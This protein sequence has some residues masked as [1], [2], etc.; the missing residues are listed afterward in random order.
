MRVKVCGVTSVADARMCVEAGVDAI[1]LSLVPGSPRRV[2]WD[3]AQEIADACRSELLV[4][5]V[6]AD[7]PKEEVDRALH[8]LK[9]GCLQF[10]GI[11]APE[12]VAA[13]LPHAYKALRARD[14]GV[15]AEAQRYAGSYL[16]VDCDVWSL[17]AP[18]AKE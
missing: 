3:A 10:D 13:Y 8:G 6:V 11:E 17:A 18:L 14:A 1:G 5:G 2:S 9:L 4:V 12:V 15:V 7:A 16:L